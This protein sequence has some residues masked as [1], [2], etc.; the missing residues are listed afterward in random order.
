MLSVERIIGCRQN[1]SLDILSLA[2][3]PG[4]KFDRIFHKFSHDCTFKLFWIIL[5]FFLLFHFLYHKF[6]C[7][8]SQLFEPDKTNFSITNLENQCITNLRQS[9][10]VLLKVFS[11][12]AAVSWKV[13]SLKDR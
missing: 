4:R 9:M 12:L 7:S 3:F 2:K 5:P 13:S 11:I 10:L 6:I 8:L 1:V